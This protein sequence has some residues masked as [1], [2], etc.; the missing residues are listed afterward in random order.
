M[1]KLWCEIEDELL[2][3]RNALH[4]GGESDCL[5]CLRTKISFRSFSSVMVLF[6]SP[7][8]GCKNGKSNRNTEAAR[9]IPP[10]TKPPSITLHLCTNWQNITLTI[11]FIQFLTLQNP[12]LCT[13]NLSSS[14]ILQLPGHELCLCS[15]ECLC[16]HMC[17]E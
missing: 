8:T 17:V 9:H 6:I 10:T 4:R 3:L 14:V 16:V 7:A 5:F 15:C 13:S 1:G 11:Y 2:S 12:G